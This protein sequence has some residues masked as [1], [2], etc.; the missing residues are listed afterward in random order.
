MHSKV[1][2]DRGDTESGDTVKLHKADKEKEKRNREP[3]KKHMDILGTGRDGNDMTGRLARQQ[4][5]NPS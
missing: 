2:G 1:R 4:R 5:E 3:K